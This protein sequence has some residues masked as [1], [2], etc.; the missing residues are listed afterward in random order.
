MREWGHYPPTTRGPVPGSLETSP[1]GSRNSQKGEGDKEAKQEEQ[2]FVTYLQTSVQCP[3][4]HSFFLCALLEPGGVLSRHCWRRRGEPLGS[5]PGPVTPLAG[6][7]AAHPVNDHM[8]THTCTHSQGHTH[9]MYTERCMHICLHTLPAAWAHM[10]TH[11]HQYICMHTLTPRIPSMRIPTLTS[12][13]TQKYTDTDT[14]ACTH[15]CTHTHV[16]SVPNLWS[17]SLNSPTDSEVS[18]APLSPP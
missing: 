15:A 13:N 2:V 5:G 4:S 6:P 11:T 8:C 10:Y 1:L 14:H 9:V 16:S 18:G 3:W 7:R 17:H 12:T